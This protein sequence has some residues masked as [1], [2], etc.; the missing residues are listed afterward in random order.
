[1]TS[2]VWQMEA[3]GAGGGA[4]VTDLTS[5]ELK[6]RF[7]EFHAEQARLS[8]RIRDGIAELDALT[9]NRRFGLSRGHRLVKRGLDVTVA[10]VLGILL[11][12]VFVAIAVTIK[13]SY[14]GRVFFPVRRI[15]K[16]GQPFLSWYFRTVRW[17]A[18]QELGAGGM[19]DGVPLEWSW[20][21]DRFTKVGWQLRRRGLD[22][23]PLLWNVL[24]GDMSLVGPRPLWQSE[25]DR[26]D[27]A[28]RRRYVVAPGVTGPWRL[29]HYEGR[30]LEEIFET[31]CRYTAAWT[32]TKDLVIL[33]KSL[34]RIISRLVN[35]A[36]R[37][38]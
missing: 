37:S 22:A 19:A 20:Q 36:P 24:R 6:R 27:P 4:P 17:Q 9:A 38:N 33:A 31:D 2:E 1:M 7:E 5:E 35:G 14:T 21:S 15:G 16:D 3:S 34:P 30:P 29:D 12:P 8:R 13:I 26:L 10:L 32:F 18:V 11:L 28:K 25:F 23:I